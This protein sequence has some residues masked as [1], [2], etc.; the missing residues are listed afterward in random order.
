[1]DSEANG[2]KRARSKLRRERSHPPAQE[3]QNHV[4]EAESCDEDGES[5]TSPASTPTPKTKNKAPRKRRRSSSASMEEDIIDGFAICSFKSL[6]DLEVSSALLIVLGSLSC[7]C[8]NCWQ[9]SYK[10]MTHSLAPK[11]LFA[12]LKTSQIC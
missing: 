10:S 7:Q 11:A 9:W 5:S 2:G 4:L 6:E 1:M 3:K 8:Q 12:W